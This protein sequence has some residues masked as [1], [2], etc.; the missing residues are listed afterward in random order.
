M[1]TVSLT[2]AKAKITLKRGRL[3]ARRALLN[4]AAERA[5]QTETQA[6]ELVAEIASVEWVKPGHANHRAERVAL[7]PKIYSTRARHAQALDQIF[8]IVPVSASALLY[9]ILEIPLPIPLG[10]KDPAPPLALSPAQTPEGCPKVDER[11]TSAALGYA[12]L[13]VHLIATLGGAAASLAYPVT[14]AGSRSHVRDVVSAMQGPRSFP[15]YGRGVERYRYEYAVFLLN[16]DIE[17]LM[18]EHDIRM[19]DM[20]HTLPNLKNLLLTMSS[21]DPPPPGPV[22]GPGWASGAGSRASSRQASYS[23]SPG[24]SGVATPRITSM[25]RVSQA[26]DTGSPRWSR[27]SDADTT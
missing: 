21:P 27:A 7:L 2:T 3:S 25:T 24:M 26:T 17:L 18:H 12:A 19:L 16:K 20:R 22:T 13:L 23:F 5:E 10:P 6:A 4:A 14:Y 9:S 8:P 15:L 11:T 1:E